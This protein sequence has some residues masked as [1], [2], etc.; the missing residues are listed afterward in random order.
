MPE[1]QNQDRRNVEVKLKSKFQIPKS[2]SLKELYQLGQSPWYD[3]I[4]RKLFKSGE[5]ALLINEYGIVGV[6]SNPAIF[7]KAISGS[8]DY[9]SQIRYLVNAR[10]NSRQIYDELTIEDVGTA[11]DM[12]LGIFKNT[13]GLD[14][15]VSIEV[16]PEYA[17]DLKRTVDYARKLFKR[18]NRSNIFI[19]V[20][21]TKEGCMAIKELISEGINVNA[22]LLFSVPHYE[23]VAR[24]YIDGLT[25]R[26]SRNAKL[27]GV[28][29]VASVFVSR[30]DTKIDKMLEGLA[31]KE[32]DKGKKE[33]I[34]NLRGR[35]AAAN[36]KMIYQNFKEIFLESR[37]DELRKKGA[38]IQRVLWA[39]TSTKN[40]DYR[41]VKYVEEL[42]GPHSINT[43]PHQTVLAF[44]DHGI[45]RPAIE[46]DLG[47]AKKILSKLKSLGID[48]NAI[49]DELQKDGVKAFSDSFNSLINAIGKKAKLLQ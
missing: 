25:G 41:D 8:S 31:A 9:D 39:S 30:L 14:G 24:A 36:S 43:M 23:A 38:H 3:N 19:K 45:V 10:K 22:T 35:A 17:Y 49:C 15:Y 40:P 11:A 46:E 20:P 37:F 2:N 13:A 48:V 6:T 27:E 32:K 12:L 28:A 26:L 42:I 33:K 5:F 16:L 1:V 21:A 7:D 29:S 18:L 4:E 47:A 44:H 34:L